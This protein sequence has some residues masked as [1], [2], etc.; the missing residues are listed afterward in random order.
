MKDDLDFFFLKK[1]GKRKFIILKVIL[2]KEWFGI[3]KQQK[4]K[5]F[6]FEQLPF[7]CLTDLTPRPLL[8]HLTVMVTSCY[9]H[10]VRLAFV[11]VSDGVNAALFQMTFTYALTASGQVLLLILYFVDTGGYF[12]AL[13]RSMVQLK[14]YTSKRFILI[15]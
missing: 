12:T 15:N 4:K 14:L 5:S 11:T 10:D 7:N 6:L 1:G 2:F 13:C 3:L 9:V 8:Q